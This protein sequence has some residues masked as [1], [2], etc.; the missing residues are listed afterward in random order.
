MLHKWQMKKCKAYTHFME[1]VKTISQSKQSYSEIFRMLSITRIEL[2]FLGTSPLCELEKK[3]GSKKLISER[4]FYFL[5]LKL[6]YWN[7]H[8]DKR[9]SLLI[10]T[11]F[12][13]TQKYISSPSRKAWGLIAWENL[14][15]HLNFQD[16]SLMKKEIL[17][18]IF[19]SPML[20]SRHSISRSGMP[21]SQKN[22][23]S[24]ASPTT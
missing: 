5:S 21:T 3:I 7:S 16:S 12:P 2:D 14:L 1:L 9:I 24:N 4:R 17:L 19:I 11:L 10:K 22:E 20:W 18:H 6:T 13:T 15:F 8:L 23:Y